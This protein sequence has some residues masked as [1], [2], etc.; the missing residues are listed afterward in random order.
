[1]TALNTA[2]NSCP[3]CHLESRLEAETHFCANEMVMNYVGSMDFFSFS[4]A[5]LCSKMAILYSV[6]CMDV[7]D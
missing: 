3:M 7:K 1:M 5:G 2:L 4:K 6:E